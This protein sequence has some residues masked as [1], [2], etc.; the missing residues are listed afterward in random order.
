M[1]FDKDF[2]SETENTLPIVC[3]G[4]CN[5]YEPILIW[6]YD[7]KDI[8]NGY[9]RFNAFVSLI[10]FCNEAL[11]NYD[12]YKSSPEGIHIVSLRESFDDVQLLLELT[13]DHVLFEK[14]KWTEDYTKLRI[15]ITPKFDKQTGKI[16]SGMPVLVSCHCT[17]G[18][19]VDHR[20]KGQF[21]IYPSTV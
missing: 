20:L 11:V 5:F 9:S 10:E 3:G 1:P 12:I 14:C 21:V 8:P 2:I 19:H 15:R 17:N 6:D 16:L 4:T 18:V 13:H 7:F